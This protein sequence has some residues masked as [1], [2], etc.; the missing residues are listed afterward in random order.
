MDSSIFSIKSSVS[1]VSSGL[2]QL[3][4]QFS[5]LQESFKDLSFKQSKQIQD[6][7]LKFRKYEAVIDDLKEKLKQTIGNA[8]KWEKSINDIVSNI[9]K[10]DH[11]RDIKKMQE[12]VITSIISLI[13]LQ[14]HSSLLIKI[15][16][17]FACS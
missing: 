8:D 4:T 14:L 9:K 5:S 17:W 2:Q 12:E 6:F 15:Q 7:E 3:E 16:C 11:D 13:F 10:K 1:S